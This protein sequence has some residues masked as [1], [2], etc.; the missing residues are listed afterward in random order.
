MTWI[1]ALGTIAA[2]SA[3]AVGAPQSSGKEVLQRFLASSNAGA[4]SSVKDFEIV[5]RNRLITTQGDMTVRSRQLFV[6][7]GRYRDESTL[8][9]GKI[10][11]IVNAKGG[12]AET[13]RGVQPLDDDQLR[14]TRE[15]VYRSYL[16]L[17]WA[18]AQGL[19][20][21]GTVEPGEVNGASVDVV[22]LRLRDLEMKGAFDS[23]SGR[24][25][26]LSSS[27]I[28]FE[29]GD[30]EEKRVFSRFGPF[31]DLTLPGEVKIY[32]DGVLAGETVASAY[33][34]DTSPDP[35]LFAQ[36]LD[37]PQNVKQ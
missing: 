25:L 6:P 7:P 13:P 10:V 18:T 17:L 28:R 4:L 31:G 1:L 22:T 14:R 34:L 15:G 29:G 20:K 36:P 21:T 24:L 9:F 2:L 16:G 11:T 8:P 5:A 35:E 32:Q 23:L 37:E 19:V 27:G 12:W 30:V 3:P 33:N 26:E